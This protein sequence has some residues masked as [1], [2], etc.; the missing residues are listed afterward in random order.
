[1]LEYVCRDTCVCVCV[2]WQMGVECVRWSVQ[3]LA[4]VLVVVTC[5]HQSRDALTDKMNSKENNSSGIS[6]PV[7]PSC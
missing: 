1:M 5:M 6:C 4:W 7:K 2:L 3:V